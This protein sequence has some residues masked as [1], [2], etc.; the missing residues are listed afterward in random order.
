MK[1]HLRFGKRTYKNQ[2]PNT[3]LLYPTLREQDNTSEGFNEAYSKMPEVRYLF[4][5]R[6]LVAGFDDISV[7]LLAT[8]EA[9]DDG[10]AMEGE[11]VNQFV[12]AFPIMRDAWNKLTADQ[13][14]VFIQGIHFGIRPIINEQLGYVQ[15]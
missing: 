11:L 4:S 12:S 8:D 7:E 14:W 13:K 2:D 5:G 1:E 10:Y 9:F 15:E 6:G 3:D